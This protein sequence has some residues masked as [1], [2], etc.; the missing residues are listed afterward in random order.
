MTSS[1]DIKAFSPKSASELVRICKEDFDVID[2]MLAMM[3]RQWD[4]VMLRMK[5]NAKTRRCDWDQR[6]MNWRASMDLSEVEWEDE[7]MREDEEEKKQDAEIDVL[8][9]RWNTLKQRINDKR[10]HSKRTLKSLSTSLEV[11]AQNWQSKQQA[12]KE[13]K[14]ATEDAKRDAERTWRDWWTETKESELKQLRDSLMKMREKLK[15]RK[16]EET[17]RWDERER[18]WKVVEEQRVNEERRS[19]R[20]VE[21]EHK[22]EIEGLK[23]QHGEEKRRCAERGAWQRYEAVW[24]AMT[25]APLFNSI[26]WPTVVP[27]QRPEDITERAIEVLLL[28]NVHSDGMSRRAR[29]KLAQLRWHPDRFTNR[30]LNCVPMKEKAKVREGMLIV[31]R[32]LNELLAS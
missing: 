25:G 21:K 8:N 3:Q 32:A 28:S 20:R 16:A 18:E 19:R 9:D 15:E 26:P 12:A 6:E 27:P 4:L 14:R 29:I 31:S 24:S 30:V 17:R 23:E 7:T 5:S 22:R 10:R 13:I 1:A 11:I 2:E